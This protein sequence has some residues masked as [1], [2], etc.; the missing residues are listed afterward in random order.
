MCKW[1][2]RWNNQPS[3]WWDIL[4]R[5]SG[6][7]IDWTDVIF[8]FRA[9]IVMSTKRNSKELIHFR[10]TRIEGQTN[11]L[12]GC[13]ELLFPRKGRTKT[14]TRSGQCVSE[15]VWTCLTMQEGIDGL[16]PRVTAGQLT[17]GF[18]S[19]GH[20]AQ[21]NISYD[22]QWCLPVQLSHWKPEQFR[23]SMADH[24]WQLQSMTFYKQHHHTSL[25]SEFKLHKTRW[26]NRHSKMKPPL[27]WYLHSVIGA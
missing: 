18:C 12:L 2:Q 6:P 11:K 13:T 8:Y 24:S 3:A 10:P 9:W 17:S 14:K 23:W 7:I 15:Y 4:T 5:S 19:H 21:H 20:W 26:H 25:K 22:V 16:P 1:L 27:C